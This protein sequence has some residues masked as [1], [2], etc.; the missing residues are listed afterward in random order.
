MTF[1]LV[2]LPS[3]PPG[4]LWIHPLCILST[5]SMSSI[6]LGWNRSCLFVPLLGSRAHCRTR[7]PFG[8]SSPSKPL[9][10]QTFFIFHGECLCLVFFYVLAS[11]AFH[12]IIL[13][14]YRN[15]MLVDHSFLPGDLQ[16][17]F[18]VACIVLALFTFDS[19]YQVYRGTCN[20]A[21]RFVHEYRLNWSPMKCR[22]LYLNFSSCI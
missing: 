21:Q 13:H 11:W 4:R 16:K 14:Q 19:T 12:L 17:K 6:W 2:V 7:L 10:H 20:Y 18:E 15:L 3:I 22:T 1:S 8:E 5:G 9:S